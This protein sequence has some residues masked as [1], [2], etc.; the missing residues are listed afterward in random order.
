MNIPKMPAAAMQR[1]LKAHL[2]RGGLAAY[3]TESCYGLG[4]L[5]THA[6]A[7]RRLIRLKKRPQHKGM[8]VIG[9]DLPQLLPLLKRPSENTQTMLDQAWPA[10]KT[11]LLPAAG[12]V[13][14]A[15]RGK[16]RSK[17]AVRVPL[18]HG[19]RALCHILKT[20]LVSTSCNCA[21]KRACKTEREVRRQ[22]GGKVM[23]IGGRTLGQKAPSMI[24]DG[25]TGRRLR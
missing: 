3:P 23:I 7:L 17:L 20:P 18:H 1:R 8:I 14:P 11:F 5:P 4:C 12:N 16:G 2:K 21:G 25:E 6:Q 15:L 22:F 10:A 13:L 9:A 24:I 19:A